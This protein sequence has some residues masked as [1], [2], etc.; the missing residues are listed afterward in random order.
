MTAPRV[1][2]VKRHRLLFTHVTEA[3]LEACTLAAHAVG[4]R[5]EEWL[6]DL[7]VAAAAAQKASS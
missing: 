1:R 4:K 3:E 2:P 6:C 7:A 5:L